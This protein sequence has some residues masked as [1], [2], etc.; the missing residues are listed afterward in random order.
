[1]EMPTLMAQAFERL[2]QFNNAEF[3]KHANFD[4]AIFKEG[5]S[6]NGT[7][8]AG[9]ADLENGR[10]YTLPD[11]IV[12]QFYQAAQSGE[13]SAPMEIGRAKRL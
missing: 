8:I 5:T 1:M 12:A 6:F 3:R 9:R 4:N 11:F 2:A 10:S 13:Y 7:G